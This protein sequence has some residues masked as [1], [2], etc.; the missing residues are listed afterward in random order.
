MCVII[1]GSEKK[2]GYEI[3]YDPKEFNQIAD[4]GY[5]QELDIGER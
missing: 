1:Y 3:N 4:G 2:E 5:E